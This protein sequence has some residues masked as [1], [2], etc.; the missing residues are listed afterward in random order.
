MNLTPFNIGYLPPNGEEESIPSV[1]WFG[2]PV[3]AFTYYMMPA[4]SRKVEGAASQMWKSFS[5]LKQ[6]AGKGWDTYAPQSIKQAAEL[7]GNVLKCTEKVAYYGIIACGEMVDVINK[8]GTKDASAS[9]DASYQRLS[10]HDQGFA[11]CCEFLANQAAYYYAQNADNIKDTISEAIRKCAT[12]EQKDFDEDSL[13]PASIANLVESAANGAKWFIDI[14]Q[15]WI[16]QTIKANI[17]HL[18]ANWA[19]QAFDQKL[20]FADQQ[21]NPVGRLISVVVNCLEKYENRLANIAQLPKD[22]QDAQ[23]RE[24]FQEI[25]SDLLT[26]FF[27]NG[28]K[29]IQLFH[30][31]IP[32]I[33]WFK[34]IIWDKINQELPGWLERLY[35]QMRP[36]NE[37]YDDWKGQFDDEAYG[38]QADQLLSLPSI[39][40]QYFIRN[41]Q[42][43]ALDAV[44]PI[45]ENVLE[46]NGLKQAKARHLSVILIKYAREFLLTKDPAL[47]KMG[48]FFERYLMEQLLFNLSQFVPDDVDMN[49]PMPLYILKQWIKGDVF[50]MLSLSLSGK[51][52]Q[53][54]DQANAIS[55]LLA[56]FGL[57][58]E[59]T[60]PLP[61]IL[62]EKIWPAI[63][64]FQ[65]EK[66]PSL[67]AKMIPQWMA[68]NH[69][70]QHQGELTSWLNNDPSLTHSISNL[71]R[72][73][74]DKGVLDLTQAHGSIG[75]KLNDLF[76]SQV[77]SQ[78]QQ[79]KLDK[80]WEDLLNEKDSIDILQTFGKHC[81]EALVLQLCKD[82]Y[83][84]YQDATLL[85]GLDVL[86]DEGDEEKVKLPFDTWLLLEVVNACQLFIQGMSDVEIETLQNAIQLRNAIYNSKDPLQAKQHHDELEKLKSTLQPKFKHLCRNL[87]ELLGYR[88]AADLPFPKQLQP[89]VW[90]KLMAILPSL[91]FEYSSDLML[92]LLEKDELK[93][94]V[95]AL[96][97]GPLIQQGCQL[98]AQDI[99]YH[100][101]DWIEGRTETVPEKIME[102]IPEVD[103]SD[104]AQEHLVNTLNAIVQVDDPIYEPLWQW[105][106]SYLEGLF[107][108]LAVKMSQMNQQDLNA[109]QSLV[110]KIKDRFLALEKK[111]E[112]NFSEEYDNQDKE[113]LEDKHDQEVQAIL[114]EFT[115]QLFACV[116]IQTNQDLFGIP[117]VLQKPVLKEIKAKIT[118]GLLGIERLGNKIRHYILPSNPVEDQLPTSQV[119]SAMLSLTHLILD[120]AKDTLAN[121]VE[122]KVE[123]R[124][125][126]LYDSLKTGLS[127]LEEKG[128]QIATLLQTVIDEQIPTPFLINLF[129]LLNT[130]FSQNVKQNLADD[131]NPALTDQVIQRLVPLLETE[132]DGQA[133][134]DQGLLM[135]VLPVLVRHFQQLN[136][137]SHSVDG[138]NIEN[139]LDIA[140]N[141]IHRKDHFYKKQAHLIF[142]LIFPNG[143]EDLAKIMPEIELTAEQWA[144]ASNSAEDLVAG[145]LPKVLDTLFN[146]ETLVKNF[147]SLFESITKQ[148]EIGSQNQSE[149]HFKELQKKLAQTILSNLFRDLGAR[150]EDATDIFT[151]PVLTFLRKVILTMSSFVIVRL[152]GSTLRFLKIERF[153]VNR[154][155]EIIQYASEKSIAVFS[156][157]ELH[158]EA[159]YQGVE[160]LEKF[161]TDQIATL[162]QSIQMKSEIAALLTEEEELIAEEERQNQMDQLIGELV[163]EVA[164][165]IDLPVERAEKLPGWTK[166]LVDIN[167]IQKKAGRAIGA[168]IRKQLDGELIAKSLQLV[169]SKLAQ[170][171]YV[172]KQ[173][174]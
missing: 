99:I 165:F 20:S 87:L 124:I 93:E 66:L 141:D 170:Q 157:P 50:K 111:E 97:Q 23:Y 133:A 167:D 109:I 51:A 29:D 52:Q 73:I 80:Q 150:F 19:D 132:K 144:A 138:L 146:K 36:L 12:S 148:K 142:K 26:K 81:L 38:L 69:L 134:F 17:L 4:I 39:L 166:R 33:K 103:L 112:E 154:L 5:F 68:L 137:A 173:E 56:P 55:E 130:A 128:Y 75:K 65:K 168:A 35:L 59:E 24:A 172:Q 123:F 16:E 98:L 153:V 48:A 41:N 1:I 22:Q 160:A 11:K 32:F 60:F 101:P 77:L 74:S 104:K 171:E 152:I 126:Q 120:K 143:Q 125:D 119:A 174:V 47:H 139:V 155:H 57:D 115:H 117:P 86:F 156:L 54:A 94:Q 116:G 114:M 28:A 110:Q 89:M 63:Q 105:V 18:S 78:E 83:S 107:L 96:P 14:S 82:L 91:L 131:I 121:G 100:F 49:T 13:S 7:T 147:N 162:D 58:Q 151:H 9:I 2:L 149:E 92:P 64:K 44:E 159:V 90:K 45:L 8:G 136:Q 163:I 71:T 70:G 84:H 53:P 129:D 43:R 30:H 67:I 88:R 61:P 135:A 21:R 76:S 161:L 42:A 145:Q 40:L 164:R 79:Q 118:Q 6:K 140:N 27:P 113:P 108:K 122:G 37:E 31:T 95:L 158:E 85:P 46:E 25:S 10:H 127:K 72:M 3:A 169:L 15:E 106:Q 102:A 62:K 34:D